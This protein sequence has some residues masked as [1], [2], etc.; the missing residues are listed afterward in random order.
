[1]HQHGK[2]IDFGDERLVEAVNVVVLASQQEMTGVFD[3]EHLL[4]LPFVIAHLGLVVDLDGTHVVELNGEAERSQQADRSVGQA[5]LCLLDS[6]QS[7]IGAQ[8]GS[9]ER[10]D[11]RLASLDL[12]DHLQVVDLTRTARLHCLQLHRAVYQLDLLYLS[13]FEFALLG[14]DLEDVI[15]QNGFF[16]GLLLRRFPRVS[17]QLFL[18]FII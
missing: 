14:P 7:L 3:L 13:R 11:Q 8:G 9:L 1:M 5:V 12:E 17:P 15:L 2:T 4:E 10:E 6:Q 18:N 16:V